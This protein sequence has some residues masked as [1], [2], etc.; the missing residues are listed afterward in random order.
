MKRPICEPSSLPV[1]RYCRWPRVTPRYMGIL[2]GGPREAYPLP[3]AP[4]DSNTAVTSRRPLRT[5]GERRPLL[6]KHAGLENW[7][8]CVRFSRWDGP[9]N[10]TPTCQSCRVS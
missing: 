7:S 2:L 9:S 4:L 5:I 10:R 6:A 1:R 8:P 3:D